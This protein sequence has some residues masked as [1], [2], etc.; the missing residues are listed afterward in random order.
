MSNSDSLL[1]HISCW[2]LAM[3]LLTMHNSNQKHSIVFVLIQARI[4]DHNMH[5]HNQRCEHQAIAAQTSI[6]ILTFPSIVFLTL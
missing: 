5:I 2:L 3:M 1:F 4:Q 6:L